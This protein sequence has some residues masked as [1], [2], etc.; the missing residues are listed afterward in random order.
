MIKITAWGPGALSKGV[1]KQGVCFVRSRFK[2]EWGI[3]RT[4]VTEDMLMKRINVVA[5][6]D[7]EIVGWLGVSEDK[8]L[9]NGCVDK[10]LNG[11]FV[12]RRLISVA[13]SKVGL[14]VYAFVPTSKLG[15]AAACLLTGQ[16]CLISENILKKKYK[17]KTI[18]LR[19]LTIL[20]EREKSESR[21]ALAQLRV[22][23]VD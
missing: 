5:I 17:G 2:D 3:F 8:E 4:D 14:P 22:I 18:L 1:I 10:K 9:V 11:V 19:K 16:K 6:S 15:S 13:I 20:P 21:S 23:E 12:L 7:G